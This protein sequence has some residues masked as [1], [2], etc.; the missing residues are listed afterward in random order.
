MLLIKPGGSIIHGQAWSPHIQV[1]IMC[2]VHSCSLHDWLHQKI[3]VSPH[4]MTI[5]STWCVSVCVSIYSI[6][7]S[8]FNF[9]IIHIQ[10]I[11]IIFIYPR[12]S[13]QNIVYFLCVNSYQT[14]N[15][16]PPVIQKKRSSDSAPQECV[17]MCTC[18]T[19]EAKHPRRRTGLIWNIYRKVYGFW[20][21]NRVAFRFSHYFPRKNILHVDWDRIIPHISRLSLSSSEHQHR[22]SLQ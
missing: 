17:K 7:S 12:Y 10:S 18:S 15:P 22:F 21:L 19:V 4:G 20:T 16:A 5:Y 13:Q 14:T 9:V 8:F 3:S 6:I 11:S 2:Q 1:I